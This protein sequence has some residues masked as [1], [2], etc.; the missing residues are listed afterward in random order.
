MIASDRRRPMEAQVV[1]SWST[2]ALD[3]SRLHW[4]HRLGLR[5]FA[6]KKPFWATEKAFPFE[7]WR[8]LWWS[9]CLFQFDFFQRGSF[10]TWVCVYGL[11]CSELS[12][13]WA[14]QL[15]STPSGDLLD[16]WKLKKELDLS[17]CYWFCT[18]L[19]IK[20]DSTETTR[21]WALYQSTQAF[22]VDKVGNEIFQGRRV[23]GNDVFVH[24]SWSFRRTV[25]RS[26]L[27]FS[28]CQKSVFQCTWLEW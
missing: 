28:V 16:C 8:D 12:A 24:T 20:S 4:V 11:K 27:F 26:V 6:E 18:I 2:A 3:R 15:I 14:L 9:L 10:S 23:E 7:F 19:S 5:N 22:L 13:A 17:K 1:K 21:P 25:K